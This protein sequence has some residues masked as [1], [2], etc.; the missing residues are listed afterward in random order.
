MDKVP[1]GLWLVETSWF[2]EIQDWL[3]KIKRNSNTDC[4][5]LFYVVLDMF[6]SRHFDIVCMTGW[7]V[8]HTSAGIWRGL[9][10]SKNT[11]NHPVPSLLCEVFF[12]L[13][14]SRCHQK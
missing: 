5:N 6:C 10:F 14:T 9:N 3:S 11:S 13:N 4:Q 7:T 8:G 2:V 1:A 12:K